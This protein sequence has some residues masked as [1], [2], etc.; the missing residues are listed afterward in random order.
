MPPATRQSLSRDA[1]ARVALRIAD[2]EG[3]EAL[4]MRRLATELGV[5]AMALYRHVRDKDDLI[6]AAVEVAAAEQRIEIEPG[7]DWR[8]TVAAI[9]GGIRARLH[10]HPGGIRMRLGRPMLTPAALELTETA[11]RAMHE[12]GFT[13]EEAARAYRSLFNYTFGSATFNAPDDVDA[14]RR[15]ARGALASL[16]EDAY[17][18]LTS[19]I[20]EAAATVGGDEQFAFGLELL[21]DGLQVRL[22]RRGG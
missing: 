13:R 14:A 21:L 10:E 12:A 9:M 17:P 7:A 19:S 20:A 22:A 15:F 5:S 16:P 3:V 11:L 4:S 8:A 2:T 1:I 6:D 18:A